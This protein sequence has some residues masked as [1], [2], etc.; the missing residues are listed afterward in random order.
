VVNFAGCFD[1]DEVFLQSRNSGPRDATIELESF[2]S[3]TPRPDS[4]PLPRQTEPLPGEARK[5]LLQEGQLDGNLCFAGP[6]MPRKN[7]E[8]QVGPVDDTNPGGV[9]KIPDLNRREL[10][11]CND[12]TRAKI[13]DRRCQLLA[14]PTADPKSRIGGFPLLE[15]FRSDTPPRGFHKPLELLEMIFEKYERCVTAGESDQNDGFGLVWDHS[16]DCEPHAGRLER[17]V[18]V[19]A[20]TRQ[21]SESA[22]AASPARM[23]AISRSARSLRLR[24]SLEKLSSEFGIEQLGNDPLLFPRRYLRPADR[25]VVALLSSLFAYGRVEQVGRNLERLLETLGDEPAA[26]L[27]SLSPGDGP[28][29]RELAGWKHRFNDENDVMALLFAIGTTLRNEGSLESLFVAGDTGGSD[30]LTALTAFA[31]AIRLRGDA[32]RPGAGWSFLVSD[33][34]KGGASK[35][36][37]LFL[38]WV[39][40]PGPIDLGLWSRVSPARLTLPMDAHLARIT[41]Y[42]GLTRRKTNDWIA[43]REAT[44]ALARIDASD[45][46]RYD[47]ALCRL[48]VLDICR[49]RPEKS[50][51]DRCALSECCPVPGGGRRIT[52]LNEREKRNLL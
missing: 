20:V 31:S 13:F 42:L 52:N 9:L 4:A 37:N 2:F 27:T 32:A 43:A 1:P 47:F 40:R 51:C 34:A 36:W 33:P 16:R 50:L 23:S 26:A 15:H 22:A 6:G 3:E 25:E 19:A 48:G 39:V 35:R 21:T 41:R 7:V 28:V 29:R 30:L 46:T 17:H 44:R 8:N 12:Q 24:T 49:A 18:R 5:L 38:R 14:L 10:P 45:P 11:L